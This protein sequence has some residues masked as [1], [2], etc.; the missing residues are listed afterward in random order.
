LHVFA[1]ANEVS[2]VEADMIVVAIETTLPLAEVPR[3]VPSR[4]GGKRLHQATAFRWAKVGVRG[5]RLETIRVGG[6]LCTS[7]EALQRFFERLSATDTD[8]PTPT[9]RTP[10]ARQRAHE[11]ADRELDQLGV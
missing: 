2:Q 8:E 3:H 4:R 11:R 6:T 7:V 10:A 1:S 5:V 9:I